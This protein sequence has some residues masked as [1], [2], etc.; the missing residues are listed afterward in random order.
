MPVR[1]PVRV[2]KHVERAVL[3]RELDVLHL[4]VMSLQLRPDPQQL[5]VDLRHLFLE[6]ADRLRRA[7]AGDDVLALGVDQ[8]IAEELVLAGIRVAGEGD[9]GPG[10]RARIAE[11]H[12]LHVDGGPLQPVIRSIRRY[13]TAFLPIQLLKTAMID[14]QS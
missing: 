8:V 4:L 11:D 14:F 5:V 2:C 10:I 7:D 9:P 3:H 6:L 1:L 12:R 13:S